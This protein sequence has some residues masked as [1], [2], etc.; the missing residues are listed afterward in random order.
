MDAVLV[1]PKKENFY[2]SKTILEFLPYQD[3]IIQKVV[4]K[5]EQEQI[6]IIKEDTLGILFE[7]LIREQEKKDL[8]QLGGYTQLI[9]PTESFLISSKGLGRLSHLFNVLKREDLLKFGTK[10][11]KFMQIAKWDKTKSVLIIPA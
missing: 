8:G 9:D 3:R 11:N 10:T 2:L 6:K 1:S 4:N 7:K 5:I